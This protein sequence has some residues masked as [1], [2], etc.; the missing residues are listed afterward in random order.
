[1]SD[2]GKAVAQCPT[3]SGS[4]LCEKNEVLD[5]LGLSAG[6]TLAAPVL[7]RPTQPFCYGTQ[8]QYIRPENISLRATAGDPFPMPVNKLDRIRHTFSVPLHRR[9]SE[10]HYEHDQRGPQF[11][12]RNSRLG[13]CRDRN[14]RINSASTASRSRH[15]TLD[16]IGR[17]SFYVETGTRIRQSDETERCAHHIYIVVVWRDT[18]HSRSPSTSWP[19]S[20]SPQNMPDISPDHVFMRRAQQ[21]VS[22]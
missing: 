15:R 4:S 18:G 3:L 21:P 9:A 5:Y 19:S 12:R 17:T 11:L 1:M 8:V 20:S 7:P 10:R 2:F 6:H 14:P 22:T 16:V 13:H